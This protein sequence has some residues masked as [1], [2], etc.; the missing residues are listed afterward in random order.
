MK[1]CKKCHQKEP[2]VSFRKKRNICRKC[3]S[4]ESGENYRRRVKNDETFLL[5][6]ATNAKKKRHTPKGI[7]YYLYLGAKNRAKHK[8]I[9][10]SISL[11]DI[12]LPTHCPILGIPLKVGDGGPSD[13]SPSLDRIDVSKGYVK[14]N[15]EVISYRANTL[16]NNA[17][18]KEIKLVYDYLVK[19]NL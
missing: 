16:K 13:N 9:E 10:F 2:S 17:T 8:K 7:C 3:A 1:E 5:K 15:I 12:V 4:I 11:S 14:G 19:H 6:C 18:S